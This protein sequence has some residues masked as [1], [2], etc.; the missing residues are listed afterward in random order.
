MKGDEIDFGNVF[1]N[2]YNEKALV[3]S[4][5]NW[6]P[7]IVELNPGEHEYFCDKKVQIKKIEA[8]SENKFIVALKPEHLGQVRIPITYTI[9]KNHVFE[10]DVVANITLLNLG[11]SVKSLE[12]S[13]SPNECDF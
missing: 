3:I 7:I 5:K 10:I 4:N 8:F 9:N 13:F 11:F 6:K 1:I 2:S 12:F